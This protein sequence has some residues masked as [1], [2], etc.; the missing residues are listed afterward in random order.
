[1]NDNEHVDNFAEKMKQKMQISA[2]KG[3]SGWD[4]PKECSIEFLSALLVDHVF[5]GDPVDVANLAMMISERNESIRLV[6]IDVVEVV[7]DHY[8]WIDSFPN[9]FE[10]ISYMKEFPSQYVWKVKGEEQ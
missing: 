8:E 9:M 4:N 7:M 2:E 1:M 6:P 5:K 3:R 10:S